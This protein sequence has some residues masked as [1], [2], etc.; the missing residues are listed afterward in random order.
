MSEDFTIISELNNNILV[1]KTN[2]Y[3]NNTGG[4]KI[5]QEFSKHQD[6]VK[7]VV[8]DLE[9]SNVV[10]SIGISYLLEIVE[11]L[12]ESGGKLFFT[13]LDPTIEK[14]FQIMG[15]FQFAEKTDSIDSVVG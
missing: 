12:N 7:K 13:N 10:N 8:I 15:I 9:K 11:S 5:A 4:E 2:G 14:T 6:S 3:I 1:L